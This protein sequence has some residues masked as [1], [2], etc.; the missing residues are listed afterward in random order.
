[1]EFNFSKWGK[2]NEKIAKT[3]LGDKLGGTRQVK[4]PTLPEDILEWID[5]A[6]PN[7]EGIK[8]SFLICPFWIPIY[9]DTSNFV[10]VVGGRQIFKSTATT[11]FIAHQATAFSGRQV[12]YVTFN[13]PNLS[14][15]SRQKLQVGTFSQNPTL[16][17]F[18]RHKLGNIHEISLKNNST[19]YMIT[20]NHE[21]KHVEGKSPSLLILDEAQYQDIQFIGKLN[22]TRT[23][24]KGKMMVFGIGGESGS[25]YEKL[26]KRTNQME[27]QYDDPNWRDR[28]Q[29]DEKG[30][31]IGNYLK[32]VLLGKWIEKN[33]DAVFYHGYH[34]PQTLFPT[35]PLTIKDA[36]EKY[37]ISPDFS[38][39]HQKNDYSPSL[40]SSH[41]LGTFYKSTRRPI[42]PEMVLKCMKPYDYISLMGADEVAELKEKYGNE[43]KISMGVDFG[44][45]PSSSATVIAILVWFKTPDIYWLAKIEPRPQENQLN[46]AEYIAKLFKDYRCDVGVGDLG[47]GANQVKLIQDGGYSNKTGIRYNGVTSSKFF[48]C[49]T[50]SDETKPFQ[51]FEKKIDEHGD[52]TGRIQIDKTTSIDMLIDIFAK[53]ASAIY[54][55]ENKL[56]SKLVIPYANPDEVGFLL[57]DLTSIT[58]KDLNQ[59]EDYTIQDGRQRPRKEYNHPPDSAMAII[60]A[61]IGVQKQTRFNWVSI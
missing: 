25:P 29:F 11:D 38:I 19:I 58:R 4:L 20:D 2:S 22:Q 9:Q 45:S 10:M 28:L 33:P 47:Y 21:Y 43:I 16:S 41:T 5:S 54:D 53:S 55:D 32:D 31:V 60:Y 42:T 14:A 39:E 27:W 44:S 7:V 12:C 56:K 17:L 52:Q 24:T 18:P 23:A 51:H 1:M 59:I 46:Q 26:W 8:R 49:R 3:I 6:R 13:E 61:L 15:F 50:I 37:K 35:I 40:F 34:I 30:L 48:G 36:V 57:D